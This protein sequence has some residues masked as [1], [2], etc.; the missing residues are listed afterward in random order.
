MSDPTDLLYR[1]ASTPLGIIVEADDVTRLRQQLYAIIRKRPLEFGNISLIPSPINP[2][3]L[4]IVNKE[5]SGE[6]T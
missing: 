1:A 6:R 4:W 5:S 3:E 2:L